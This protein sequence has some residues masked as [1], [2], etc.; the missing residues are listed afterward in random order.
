MEAFA[1]DIKHN[2]KPAPD[3][4]FTKPNLPFLIEEILSSVVSPDETDD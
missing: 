4:S 1:R 2:R 3:L